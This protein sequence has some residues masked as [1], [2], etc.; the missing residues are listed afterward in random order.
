[1]LIGMQTRLENGCVIG[2]GVCGCVDFSLVS[3]VPVIVKFIR[4]PPVTK[5]IP[6]HSNQ[7]ICAPFVGPV[8][9]LSD[10]FILFCSSLFLLEFF[11]SF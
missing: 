2:D 6:F 1:M 8:F 3:F 7:R 4:R 9:V 5:R 10:K 11:I